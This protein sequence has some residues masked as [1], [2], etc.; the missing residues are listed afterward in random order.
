[1][2][3]PFLQ[4]VFKNIRIVPILIGAPTRESFQKLVSG[5]TKAVRKNPG[6]IIIASSDLSHYHDDATARMMD[7]KVID[8]VARMSLEE[9]EKDL[10]SGAGEMCGGF[11]VLVTM[12]IARNLG[13]T[14]GVLFQYA[15]SGDVT[16]DRSR[17]VGYTAMGLVRSP[18]TT[19]QRRELLELARK[20]VFEYVTSGKAPESRSGD[21]RLLANGAVFVTINKKGHLRGCIGNI[22]P[23]MPLTQAVVSNATSASARD[24]RFPAVTKEELKDLQ[25]EVT[26][27]SPL[28]PL[29]D[30]ADIRIGTHGLYLINGRNTGI[31]LPQVAD[32]QKWDVQT[33]LEQV[34]HKAGLPA[35]AWK[36]SELFTFTADIIR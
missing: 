23:L 15:N 8:T 18:L 36:N 20:T 11:P 16:G 34:S 14:H 9:L 22:Q 33:F 28:E 4:T 26:V 30:V 27:L 1:V 21:P 7:R 32:N 25:I 13:A 10:S 31:L 2:Q 6:T 3:F 24:P 29:Q 35:Q 17:V 5:L 19:G 12:A